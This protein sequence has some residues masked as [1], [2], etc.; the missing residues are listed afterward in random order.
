VSAFESVFRSS[1]ELNPGITA[2]W[3]R[4][5]CSPAAPPTPHVHS[6]RLDDAN[7][8]GDVE[9]VVVSGQTHIRLL[10]TIRPAQHAGRGEDE[11]IEASVIDGLF[12]LN[13]QQVKGM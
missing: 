4:L 1:I 5:G 2:R 7:L 10:D 8:V 6:T 11:Q 9:C 12:M 13:S 3:G